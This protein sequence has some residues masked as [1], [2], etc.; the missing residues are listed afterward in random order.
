MQKPQATTKERIAEVAPSL[1]SMVKMHNEGTYHEGSEA[2]N[3][4]ITQVIQDNALIEP[5]NCPPE[6]VATI[7]SNREFALLI[8][9]DVS[10]LVKTFSTNGFN[11]ELW[12]A[13]ACTAPS[14]LSIANEWRQANVRVVGKSHGL[15]APITD[16]EALEL[17]TARGS[18]GSAALRCIKLGALCSHA[19]LADVHGRISMAKV[20][21][22]QPTL[23]PVLEHGAQY[24]VIPGDLEVAVPGLMQVLSRLGNASNAVYRLP[25]ALQH[26]ARIHSLAN[27]FADLDDC[28]ERVAKVAVIGMEPTFA[29]DVLKYINF[30]QAWSGGKNPHVLRDLEAYEQSLSDRRRLSPNDL[31]LLSKV[32]LMQAPRIVPA[33]CLS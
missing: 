20:C 17:F 8:P 1:N 21:E 11:P 22:L 18:H 24:S 15:L 5:K 7:P 19:E 3:A 25:T 28:W 10:F 32:D 9:A 23:K 2:L 27:T 30:V 33:S 14:D 4:K 13:L 26:C 12:K 29:D 31:L 6:K 16:P